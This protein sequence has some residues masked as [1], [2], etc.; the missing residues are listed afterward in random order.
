MR[1]AYKKKI[2]ERNRDWMAVAYT[3]QQARDI[4][5]QNRLALVLGIE[6]NTLGNWRSEAEADDGWLSL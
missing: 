3:P 6:V 5:G 2:A 4:I 1:R